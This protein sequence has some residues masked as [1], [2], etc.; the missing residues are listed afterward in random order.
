MSP[1]YQAEYPSDVP[2]NPQIRQFLEKFYAISD[3]ADAHEQY[4]DSFTEN[5]TL[6]MGAKTAQ[7]RPGSSICP[8]NANCNTQ[9]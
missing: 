6:V 5:A 7:G 9:Q 1:N 8:H 3:T 2:F 4:A